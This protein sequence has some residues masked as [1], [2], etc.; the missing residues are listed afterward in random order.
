MPFHRSSSPTDRRS[1]RDRIDAS[2]SSAQTPVE[3]GV[4]VLYTERDESSRRPVS[5][6]MRG[7][8]T[9]AQLRAERD[10]ASARAPLTRTS[11]GELLITTTNRDGTGT[12]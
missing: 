8:V 11:D 12:Q 5:R 6:E 10:A 7:D 3:D 2:R 4:L 9:L 1:Q